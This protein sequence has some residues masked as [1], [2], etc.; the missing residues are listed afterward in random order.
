MADFQLGDDKK[1][2]PVIKRRVGNMLLQPGIQTKMGIYGIFLS[3]AFAISAVAIL[4][5]NFN[6]LINTILELTDAREDMED[7]LKSYLMDTQIWIFT[8]FFV[9]ILA[10]IGVSVWFTHRMVGPTVA[11]KRHLNELAKGNYR[12][13][14]NLR[15][16][17][18]FVDVAG[19]LNNLSDTLE[20]RYGHGGG[21][22][23][24]QTGG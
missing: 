14:T 15:D 6:E 11:F 2:A 10:T 3:L 18:A 13:R 7:I 8:A 16:G 23:P 19:A 4:W 1:A 22:S 21:D 9:Y 17:D 5:L 12:I 24:G 20:K